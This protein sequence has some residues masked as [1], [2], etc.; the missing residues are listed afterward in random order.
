MSSIPHPQPTATF[1]PL[2]SPEG[3][4]RTLLSK[5]E[6]ASDPLDQSD[7]INLSTL[8]Q[9]IQHYAKALADLP[10]IREERVENIKR[11]LEKGTYSISSQN[12]ADKLIQEISDLP[13]G[14]SSS[15]T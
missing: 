3:P 1:L 5:K 4:Q 14:S 10:D 9:E 6:K 7:A 2:S 13:S 11:S 12:L 15:S 8:Q